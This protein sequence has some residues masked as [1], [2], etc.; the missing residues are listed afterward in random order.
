MRKKLYLL[1]LLLL[2]PSMTFAKNA[3]IE[4]YNVAP[5]NVPHSIY[6]LEVFGINSDSLNSSYYEFIDEEGYYNIVYEID[7]DTSKLGWLTMDLEGN[8]IKEKTIPTYL[9]DFGNAVYYQKNLYVL[10][11]RDDKTTLFESSADFATTV[12]V[13]LVKYDKNGNVL[14]TLALPGFETSSRYTAKYNS[15]TYKA[16]GTAKAF[17][18]NVNLAAGNG[19]IACT[20]ARE[21]YNGHQMGYAMFVKADNLEYIN[22]PS[23]L[24]QSVNINSNRWISHS[25]EQRV[26][27]TSDNEFLLVD[28]GDGN[29]RTYVVAKTHDLN[30]PTAMNVYKYNTFTFREGS[31]LAGSYNQIYTNLGNIIEVDDGYLLIADS[32]RTLSLNYATTNVA[33]ESRDIFIQ[34]MSKDFKNKTAE[35]LQ[36]FSAPLRKSETK[37]TSVENLGEFELSNNEHIDYGVKWLTDLDDVTTAIGLRAVKLDNGNIAILW[38]EKTL[39]AKTTG[40][41]NAVGDAQYYYMIIDDDGNIV[42]EKT[43]IEGTNLTV[44][45][46]YVTK[47]NSIYWSTKDKNGFIL[48]KLDT[49]KDEEELIFERVQDENISI[50]DN[51]VTTYKLSVKTNRNLDLK[52]SSNKEDVATVDNTGNVTIKNSGKVTITVTN[53][54]YNL[55][56][57]YNLDIKYKASSITF[58]EEILELYVGEEKT[59]NFVVAPDKAY[60]KTVNWES[61][62]D[63]GFNIVNDN[64]KSITLRGL[65]KGN[66]YLDGRINSIDMGWRFRVVVKERLQSLTFPKKNYNIEKGKK[67]TLEPIFYPNTVKEEIKYTYDYGTSSS[68]VSISSDGVVTAGNKTG[69]AR[70]KVTAL[71]SNVST[72]ITFYVVETTL[73][74][75]S[76]HLNNIGDSYSL[77]LTTYPYDDNPTWESTNPLVATVNK[78]LVKA[79]GNGITTIKVTTSNGLMATCTVTVGP[80]LPGDL[81]IDNRV[82]MLDAYMALKFALMLSYP[83]DSQLTIGDMDNTNKIDMLDT[84]VILKMALKIN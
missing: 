63:T 80:Y 52:W 65:K 13:E 28:S 6:S 36:L 2:I 58:D 48:N 64:S 11:G 18:A 70:Y 14:N 59:F 32:E 26:I 12:T 16:Y 4:Q 82:D 81:N 7:D 33:N 55:S 1:I 72:Y 44:L 30:K 50:T 68:L 45:Y 15:A 60:D 31:D 67:I 17:K 53:E 10:Y 62:N 56:L 43:T 57:T 25:L 39:K 76:I 27:A 21:M 37:R 77:N 23:L 61:E 38:V 49:T 47:D 9:E 66:Y 83:T 34:K 5:K 79:I 69:F 29:P 22:R 71:E 41:Y 19:I 42:K 54:Q 74:K 8:I 75:T 78:G 24:T 46:N 84:Y 73:D 35:T 3:Y 51:N 20:F 40:G